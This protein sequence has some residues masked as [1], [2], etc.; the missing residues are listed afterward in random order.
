MESVFSY[1]SV[2]YLSRKDGGNGELIPEDFPGK[3]RIASCKEGIM[4]DIRI[5][6]EIAFISFDDKKIRS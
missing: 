2:T 3:L 5:S 1:E 6:N 4:D